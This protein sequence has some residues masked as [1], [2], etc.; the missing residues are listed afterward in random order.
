MW[1]KGSLTDSCVRCVPKPLILDGMRR[2]VS[3]DRDKI[4]PNKNDQRDAELL[5][6]IGRFDRKLLYPMTHRGEGAQTDLAEVKQGA[7]HP[8]KDAHE[9]DVARS[10]CGQVAW[11]STPEMLS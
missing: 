10:Q 1:D 3:R 4:S 7:G 8:G 2:P 9:A 5:A 6:R 11:A